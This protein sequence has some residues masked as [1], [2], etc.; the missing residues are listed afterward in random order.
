MESSWN[1]RGKIARVYFPWKSLGCETGIAVLQDH[2]HAS[3]LIDWLSCGFTS[4]STQNRSFRRRYSQ[5]T[6]WLST[7]KL[8]TTKAS[9]TRTKWPKLTWKNSTEQFWLS[10]LLSPIGIRAQTLS[11]GIWR[12]GN[13][14]HDV[15]CLTLS[16]ISWLKLLQV[17][18]S[19]QNSNDRTEL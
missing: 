13:M 14:L 7:E 4:H 11:I 16:S 15:S 3:W 19:D 1:P 8:N 18:L 9:N 12:R 17:Y 2:Q 6:S 10:S 5:P